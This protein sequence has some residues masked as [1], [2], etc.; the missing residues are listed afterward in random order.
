MAG[1]VQ[2]VTGRRT[3]EQSLAKS[4]E[5]LSTI[6]AMGQTVASSFDM[7]EIYQRVLSAGRQ[8][9]ATDA[10]IFFLHEG[11]ELCIVA[12]NQVEHHDL[13]GRRIPESGGVAGEALTMARP[14]W[15]S[16]QECLRRRWSNWSKVPDWTRAQSSPCR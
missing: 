15:L 1:I 12:V 4:V 16:G 9:L 7:E 8:L 14:V 3:L 5:Q 11:N 10:M 2:D 13:M 6:D